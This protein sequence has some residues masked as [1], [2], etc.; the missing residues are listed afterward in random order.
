MADYIDL[1]FRRFPVK[2][3]AHIDDARPRAET[4]GPSPSKDDLVPLLQASIANLYAPGD[5]MGL[6]G[7]VNGRGNHAS[8]GI[9]N[10]YQEHWRGFPEYANDDLL[11]K[12][13]LMVNFSSPTG[14]SKLAQLTGLTITPT[15]DSIWF[16]PIPL[17]VLSD[18]HYVSDDSAD[19]DDDI[20]D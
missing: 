4:A 20:H 16:P 8:I 15:T 11:P 9:D 17:N 19:D 5:Q 3:A 10:Y 2:F 12:D 13:R 18:K 6:F 7:K 14:R 1:F